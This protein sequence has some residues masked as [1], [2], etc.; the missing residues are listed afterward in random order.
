VATCFDRSRGVASAVAAVALFADGL[1]AARQTASPEAPTAPAPMMAPSCGASSSGER[2][3]G[4]G[5][6]A[7]ALHD[8]ALD[9]HGN[10]FTGEA[11]NGGRIQKFSR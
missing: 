5:Q 6:F 4:P 2:G 11:A 3:L 1:T 9:S 10:L 7:T 8:I